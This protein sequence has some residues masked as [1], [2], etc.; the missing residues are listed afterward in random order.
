M[1]STTVYP[2]QPGPDWKKVR[3]HGKNAVKTDTPAGCIA[4]IVLALL[5]SWK[6]AVFDDPKIIVAT[7]A[8]VMWV[9][10]VAGEMIRNAWAHRKEPK[11]IV[12][13]GPGHRPN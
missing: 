7:V 9:C 11:S 2:V 8:S 10:G 6:P 4:I 3:K 5:Q 1:R 13:I 12:S